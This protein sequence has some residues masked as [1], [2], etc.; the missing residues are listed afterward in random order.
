METRDQM[1]NNPNDV[2]KKYFIVV[3]RVVK[4]HK[5]ASIFLI[6]TA[7]NCSLHGTSDGCPVLVPLICHET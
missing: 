2:V 6:H 1:R 5:C 4:K 3:N 7:D